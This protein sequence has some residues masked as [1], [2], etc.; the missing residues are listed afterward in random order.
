MITHPKTQIANAKLTFAAGI[1][2]GL[3]GSIVALCLTAWIAAANE[4]LAQAATPCKHDFSWS[5]PP[6]SVPPGD[7]CGSGDDAKDFY[8]FSWQIFKFLVWPASTQR[9]IP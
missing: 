3:T 7:I 9:G 6:A 1:R 4:A 2:A 5:D 8:A